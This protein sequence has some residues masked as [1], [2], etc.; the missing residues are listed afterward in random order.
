MTL[1]SYHSLRHG[2]LVETGTNHD[3]APQMLCGHPTFC[4]LP[5]PR[6][7]LSEQQVGREA[8]GTAS[9]GVPAGEGRAWNPWQLCTTCQSKL[10]WAK[11]PFLSTCNV[12]R[13]MTA[14]ASLDFILKM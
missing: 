11:C 5:P 14:H 13:F 4:T 3:L 2:M 7:A 1:N 8:C 12:T 10:N 9:D 6:G